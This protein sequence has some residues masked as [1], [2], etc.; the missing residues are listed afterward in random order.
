MSEPRLR[1]IRDRGWI[2]PRRQGIRHDHAR[3]RETWPGSS[4]GVP[5]G[6]HVRRPRHVY[7]HPT[8]EHFAPLFVTLGSA[9]SEAPVT[10]ITGYWLGLAKRSIQ[11][12]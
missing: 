1:L 9:D 11:V 10:T 5:T 12:A 8:T 6:Q 7:A 3:V 2:R 4:G